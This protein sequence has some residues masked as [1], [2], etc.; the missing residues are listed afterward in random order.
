MIKTKSSF[1]SYFSMIQDLRQQ[2]K[3]LHNLMDVMFIAVAAFIAGADDWEIVILFAE[4]HLDWLKKFLELPNGIP[5]VHTFRQVFRMIDPKQFEKCFIYWVKEIA[6]DTKG[7]VVAID[8]K[9]AQHN[10]CRTRKSSYS[11]SKHLDE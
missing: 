8:G 7:A 3:V 1:A 11:Y 5:S 4:T 6:S 2:G 10:R 9:T